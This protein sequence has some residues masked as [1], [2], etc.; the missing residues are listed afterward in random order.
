MAEEKKEEVWEG[1]FE[2][3]QIAIREVPFGLPALAK[4][5]AEDVAIAQKDF[6]DVNFLFPSDYSNFCVTYGG[7]TLGRVRMFVFYSFDKQYY[8]ER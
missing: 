2:R 5:S 8:F 3:K 1:F 4:P 7:G 6:E